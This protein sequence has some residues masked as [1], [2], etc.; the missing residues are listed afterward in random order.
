MSQ[1]PK[2]TKSL[3]GHPDEEES[4]EVSLKYRIVFKLDKVRLV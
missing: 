4:I 2:K 1:R 3:Q